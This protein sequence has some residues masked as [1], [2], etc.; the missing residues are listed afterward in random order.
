MK[1][2]KMGMTIE[3]YIKIIKSWLY[4]G[5]D[6]LTNT[7][8]GYMEGWFHKTDKEAFETAITIM[9]KYQKIEQIIK[10]HDNDRMP[11]D[12]WYIDRIREVLEDGND[13]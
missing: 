3:D 1:R 9:H 8:L 4:K 11:E 10:D 5:T 2:W 6:G 12:Y 13:D 7:R